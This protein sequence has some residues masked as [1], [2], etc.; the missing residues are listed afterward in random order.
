MREGTTLLPPLCL[1]FPHFNVY[2]FAYIRV[3]GK[4]GIR[5]R[6]KKRERENPGTRPEPNSPQSLVFRER[7]RANFKVFPRF[8]QTYCRARLRAPRVM[9]FRNFFS[10][11]DFNPR[12]RARARALV[13]QL[14]LKDF[15]AARNTRRIYMRAPQCYSSL[16]IK[17]KAREPGKE[18]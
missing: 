2:I 10:P 15:S 17:R 11:A 13:S 4:G 12:A 5:R 14:S 1:A 9:K 6:V 8:S 16:Q 7:R 3:G 18:G